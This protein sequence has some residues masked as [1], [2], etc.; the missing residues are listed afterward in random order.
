M[1]LD[2][3]IENWLQRP[4]V[5]SVWERMMA[6]VAQ[7]STVGGEVAQLRGLVQ[8]TD[9][10]VVRLEAEVA[11]L[12]GEIRQMKTSTTP[13][14]PLPKRGHRGNIRGRAVA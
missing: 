5:E 9:D 6:S 4:P 14:R 12:T 13:P 2:H 8:D 7:P 1:S 3:L 10:A 11:R